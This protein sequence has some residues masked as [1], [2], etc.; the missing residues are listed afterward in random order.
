MSGIRATPLQRLLVLLADAGAAYY[1]RRGEDG[2][3]NFEL[4]M[5]LISELVLGDERTLKIALARVTKPFANSIPYLDAPTMI[6][7][8]VK[9]V[10]RFE[11]ALLSVLHHLPGYE[12][13]T[14]VSNTS[15]FSGG[16]IFPLLPRDRW[17]AR[18]SSEDVRAHSRRQVVEAAQ[19][20]RTMKRLLRVEIRKNL[21]DNALP[22]YAPLVNEAERLAYRLVRYRTIMDVTEEM[23]ERDERRSTSNETALVS[24]AIS[25]LAIATAATPQT[26]N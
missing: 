17:E 22:E 25:G 9:D 15:S 10:T 12:Q 16:S 8:T 1:V 11:T 13:L 19:L 2:P 24:R 21:R 18:S 7:C 5:P 14:E 3:T 20:V 4:H 23:R 26:A 6:F